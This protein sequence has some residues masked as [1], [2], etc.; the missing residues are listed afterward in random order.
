MNRGHRLSLLF[1][2]LFCLCTNAQRRGNFERYKQLAKPIES[3]EEVEKISNFLIEGISLNTS[4]EIAKEILAEN[5]YEEVYSGQSTRIE[6]IK[7]GR[8]SVVPGDSN[9]KIVL[10]NDA[11]RKELMFTRQT[12]VDPKNASPELPKTSDVTLAKE[13]KEILCQYTKDETEKWTICSPDSEQ[14]ISLGKL[15]RK[16]L[17]FGD[18]LYLQT[19]QANPQ[20]GGIHILEEK[21]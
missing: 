20:N 19:L 15:G 3:F 5:G 6:F 21:N 17:K 2:I 14:K 1:I 10:I 13:L 11:K 18:N 8:R 4:L 9:F 12:K 16:W 7:N